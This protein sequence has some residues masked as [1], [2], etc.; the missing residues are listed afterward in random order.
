MSGPRQQVRV[1]AELHQELSRSSREGDGGGQPMSCWAGVTTL[2]SW[3]ATHINNMSK[4]LSIEQLKDK[5]RFCVRCFFF[6]EVKVSAVS[7]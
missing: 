6:L 3:K 7:S 2:R 1:L 4:V 5:C